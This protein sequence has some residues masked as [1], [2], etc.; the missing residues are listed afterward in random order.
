[1]TGAVARIATI[2]TLLLGIGLTSGCNVVGFFGAIEAERRRTGKTEVKAEY[3][4]LDGQRVALVI[5]AS[6]EIYMTSPQVVNAIMV[7]VVARLQAN[8]DIES[9]VQPQEVVQVMYDDPGLLDRTYDE[10]AA[11]FGVTRLIVIQ[12]D[13]FRLAEMGNQYVW[14]GLAAGNLLV[15]EAD[16]FIE[17]DVRLERYVNVTYPDR[18]NT[19]VDEMTG[20]EVALEL[21]RRFANRTSW[22][23]YDHMERYP[24]YRTY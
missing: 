4:G 13:E 21:L 7:E 15:I 16:S 23:F 2:T 9:I 1:M 20:Q 24:E 11:R 8:A 10:I 22:F 12:L 14:S 6:R 5:D 17:D 18:P 3:E 19:T